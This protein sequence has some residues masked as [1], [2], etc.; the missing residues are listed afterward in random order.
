M[1]VSVQVDVQV[2]AQADAQADVQVVDG[3]GDCLGGA[4][5]VE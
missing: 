5:D 1:M 2:D 3:H 4:V